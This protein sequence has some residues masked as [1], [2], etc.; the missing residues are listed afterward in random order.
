[1]KKI[2]LSISLILLYCCSLNTGTIQKA[3]KSYL[4][5]IGKAEFVTVIVDDDRSFDLNTV[6]KNAV[7]QIDPGKHRIQIY[8]SG[9]L[10][11]DRVV[12]V[13]DQGTMEILLP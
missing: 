3:E 5:F 10:V 1:M 2:I 13:E 4:K 12:F 9:E 6:E 11:V 8:R 7:Y